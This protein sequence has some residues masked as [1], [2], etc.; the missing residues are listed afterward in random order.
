MP[1]ARWS[2]AIGL[3]AP[4]LA[5]LGCAQPQNACGLRVCDIRESDC[6]QATAVA[7]ACLRGVEPVS[8]PMRVIR[9][10][11][12]LRGQSTAAPAPE[13]AALH[14]RWNTGLSLLGLAPPGMTL[15]EANAA[16]AGQVAAF[17]SNATDGITIIDWGNPLDSLRAVALLVHE[18]T[19]ALQDH[20][21]G[22]GAYGQAF[23]GDNDRSL[24]SGAIIEGEANHV[25]DLAA[26]DLYGSPREGVPWDQVFDRYLGA[27]R[28]R[29]HASEV[30][31]LLAW[32][33]FRYPFGTAFVNRTWQ[34]NGWEGVNGL[35]QQP[36]LS[37]RQILAGPG[38]PEPAAGPWLEALG[39]EAVPVLPAEFVYR[40]ADTL[41]AWTLE[42]FMR[43]L[44]RPDLERTA[45]ENLR[46]DMFS[47]FTRDATVVAYWRLRLTTS[48]LADQ[49]AQ[50]MNIPDA[51][52]EVW[53]LGERDLAIGGGVLAVR[54]D[55]WMPIP[56]PAPPAPA[57]SPAAWTCGRREF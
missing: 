19:H 10:E 15:Q 57:M 43:R 48:A 26:I 21:V 6:Q 38:S 35:L 4:A 30:P 20:T 40:H 14:E 49:L 16:N 23:G 24:A 5:L 18:Y 53:R 27:A 47:V 12:W 9:S 32:A 54:A 33:H 29:L 17:Y 13:L 34:A 42:T 45:S 3:L 2:T 7:A 39:D 46:G 36:P 11:D 25:Q 8:V 37:T 41:G 31:V 28:Q 22:L 52:W 44:G 56:A 55:L 50:A 51:A 1:G